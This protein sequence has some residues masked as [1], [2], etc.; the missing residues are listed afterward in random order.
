MNRKHRKTLA[1]IFA[2]PTLA[3]INWDSAVSSL[4]SMGVTIEPHG[5]SIYSFSFGGTRHII[6]KPHPG[7]ELSKPGV[8]AFREFCIAAGIGPT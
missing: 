3:N 4:A 7:H 8:R 2:E 6:H 1:A 5:G